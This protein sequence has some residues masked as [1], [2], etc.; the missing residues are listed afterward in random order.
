M[1]NIGIICAHMCSIT[2]GTPISCT[3][4]SFVSGFSAASTVFLA[5]SPSLQEQVSIHS[6]VF[7]CIAGEGVNQLGCPPSSSWLVSL[8]PVDSLHLPLPRIICALEVARL[9]PSHGNDSKMKLN[10][11]PGMHRHSSTLRVPICYIT[12]LTKLF[13]FRRPLH[14]KEFQKEGMEPKWLQTCNMVS[15]SH[16]TRTSESHCSWMCDLRF[17]VGGA[18]A[19][20]DPEIGQTF[21]SS[22]TT[23]PSGCLTLFCQQQRM[24]AWSKC[25]GYILGKFAFSFHWIPLP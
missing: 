14:R 12:N 23:S 1:H 25:D 21:S 5:A 6:S 16:E 9:R 7:H 4:A 3:S 19:R 24:R 18:L 22:C 2:I 17:S 8:N 15:C 13:G 20:Y 11:S 10:W